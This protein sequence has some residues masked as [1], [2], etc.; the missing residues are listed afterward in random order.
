MILVVASL[1]FSTGPLLYEMSPSQ[2]DACLAGLKLRN[3]SF[4]ER[5]SEVAGQ[6]LGTPYV[7]DPLG[8][9]PDGR[10]DKD[11]LMDLG[12]VD[13]V[14]FIE[15][16]IALAA[17]DSYQNAFNL[18]QKIRY[19]NGEI[20]F[21][22]RNHFMIADWIANNPF[23]HDVSGKLGVSTE[24]V[25]RKMGRKHFYE[26]KKLPKLARDATEETLTLAYVPACAVAEAEK[27]LP[28]PALILFIG[29]VDWLFTLH[30]GL[31]IRAADGQGLLYNA[32]SKA[33]KVVADRFPSCLTSGRYLG[34]TA[35][36]IGDPAKTGAGRKVSCS[37]KAKG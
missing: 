2:V 28:S 1:V 26:V 31:Y 20:A 4:A 32:S 6:S 34:F 33:G 5:V 19:K 8:E 14:T 27:R 7:G 12:R 21:D 23:C 22:K 36:E 24:S 30:C 17:A 9:G 10:Y 15:Q 13:C 16:T 37:S 35:Y 25:T 3:L 29:K 18:L 11:P